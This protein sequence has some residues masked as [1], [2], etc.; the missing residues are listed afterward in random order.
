MDLSERRQILS[1]LVNLGVEVTASFN[2]ISTP[3]IEVDDRVKVE[4]FKLRTGLRKIQ[5]SLEQ[6]RFLYRNRDADIFVLRAWKVHETLPLFFF[7][8]KILKR[9]RP[10]F[11]LDIRTLPVDLN[12]GFREYLS[13]L[14]F[15]SSLQI[16][17]RFFDG[18]TVITE[19]MK[20]FVEN[21]FDSGEKAIGVWSTGVDVTLFNPFSVA[22]RRKQHDLEGKFV[23]MYHGIFSPNRGLQQAIMAMN[24]VKRKYPD[25]VLFLLGSGEAT[26]E[27]FAIM[28]SLDLQRNVVIHPAVSFERVPSFVQMADVGILPF[29]SCVEWNTSSPIKLAEYMAMGK[30]CLVTDIPAHR[31]VFGN[32]PFGWYI[33]ECSPDFIARAIIDARVSKDKLGVIGV[34]ARKFAVDKLSWEKQASVIKEYFENLLQDPKDDAV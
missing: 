6:Q 21:H 23:V 27:L 2:Y 10:K 28:K 26:E 16:A 32:D 13:V 12:P 9:D 31:A 34:Q 25:V 29:P 19:E 17:L 15:Q 8:K 1:A 33:A 5:L 20:R 3:K 7:L 18:L 30:P 4:L 24:I 11:V 22:D 14:R